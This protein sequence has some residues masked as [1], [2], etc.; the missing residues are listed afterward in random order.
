MTKIE[1]LKF[2]NE[3]LRKTLQ[4]LVSKLELIANDNQFKGI[5][6]LNHVHGGSYTGPTWTEEFEAAKKV[7]AEL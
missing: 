3:L 7:L 5:F 4:D 6:V 2:K 1:S